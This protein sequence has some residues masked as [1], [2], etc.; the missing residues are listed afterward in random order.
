MK[1][2]SRRWESIL[3]EVEEKEFKALLKDMC[4]LRKVKFLG[5]ITPR[6]GQY[7]QALADGLWRHNRERYVVHWYTSDGTQRMGTLNRD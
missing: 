7:I 6:E 4:K 2:S 1:E 5:C 3:D